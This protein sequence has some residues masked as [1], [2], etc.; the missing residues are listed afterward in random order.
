MRTALKEKNKLPFI[1]GS[2]VRSTEKE[3]EEFSKCHAW[4]IVNLMVCSW[5]LNIIDPKLRM[6][7]LYLDTTKIM[8]DDLKK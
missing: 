8:W 5:L 7:I 6:T 4:D 3:D 2:L 1:N